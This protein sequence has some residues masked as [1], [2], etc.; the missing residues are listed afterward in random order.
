MVELITNRTQ[1]HV[2]LLNALLKKGWANLTDTE[3]D[4]WYAEAAKGAYNYTDLNRV[5]SAVAEIAESLGL[6]LDTKT[7]WTLWDV[8]TESD[9][10]RYLGNVEKIKNAC[11]NKT[12]FPAVPS[13]MARL[14]YETA[15]RIEEILIMADRSSDA[16][17]RSGELYCGE[18]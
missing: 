17:P 4:I 11:P 2:D 9:M 13:R 12:L 18:V 6:T 7:D 10:S 5:E 3:K 1:E 15:N 14:T 16:I 8:P